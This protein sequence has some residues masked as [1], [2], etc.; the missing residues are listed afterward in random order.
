MI[1]EFRSKAAGGFFMTEPVARLV[2]A[3][4]GREFAPKG[5]F[6]DEQV[7][8]MRQ[9]LE[10]AIAGAR[11]QDRAHQAGHEAAVQEGAASATDMP[12]GLSQRAYPLLEMLRAAER[13]NVSVVWGV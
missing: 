10:E 1:I 12:V 13:D 5:I 6:T 4:L 2:L 3:A 7:P 8:L 9:R 11:G